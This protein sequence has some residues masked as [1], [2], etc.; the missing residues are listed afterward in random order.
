M[1]HF[2]KLDVLKRR[3]DEKT[4]EVKSLQKS[5]AAEKL[6][7]SR[8]EERKALTIDGRAIIQRAVAMT[9]EKLKYKLSSIVTQALALVFED[10]YEFKVEFVERRNS[11]ECD[12]LFSRGGE[13]YDPLESAGHGAADIASF[14]LR[15][16][17]WLLSATAPFILLDEPFRHLSEDLQPA[18]AEMLKMLSKEFGLQFLIIS[19]EQEITNCANLQHDF[20]LEDRIT[21][22]VTV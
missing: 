14:T 18:A 11:T 16:S 10:P 12:L 21:R 1:S 13:D 17:Y 19:H 22:V 5:L 7:L 4:G 3:L 15:I 8:A 2:S 6:E 20:H 9:Q